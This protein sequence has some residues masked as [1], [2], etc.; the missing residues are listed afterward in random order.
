MFGLSFIGTKG[1]FYFFDKPVSLFCFPAGVCI[2]DLQAS[3]DNDQAFV[4]QTRKGGCVGTFYNSQV[5]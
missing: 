4:F 3:F 1:S 5:K 2:F